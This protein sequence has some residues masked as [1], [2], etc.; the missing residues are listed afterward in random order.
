[1]IT[2]TEVSE[3]VFRDTNGND[4]PYTNSLPIYLKLLLYLK[5]NMTKAAQ[6][7]LHVT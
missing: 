1:M 7:H 3:N 4:Y 6:R 2:K 5:I